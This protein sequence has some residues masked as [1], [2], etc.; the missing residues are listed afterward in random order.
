MSDRT[1]ARTGKWIA[2]EAAASER[3]ELAPEKFIKGQKDLE[4]EHIRI[5]RCSTGAGESVPCGTIA[6]QANAS[7][8]LTKIRSMR[9]SL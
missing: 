1:C 9:E 8:S 5:R 3:E 4:V 6:S 7:I 2:Q